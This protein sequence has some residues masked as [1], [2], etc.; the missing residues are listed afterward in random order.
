MAEEQ[1]RPA[2]E[3]HMHRRSACPLEN[4][5]RTVDPH[6]FGRG[7]VALAHIAHDRDLA[8]GNV[9]AAITTQDGTRIERVHVRVTT[10]CERL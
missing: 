8:G 2:A 5:I 1:P 10:A 7:I 6:N 9:A 4:E 3:I